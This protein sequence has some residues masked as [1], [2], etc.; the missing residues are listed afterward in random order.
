VR[1]IARD[2]AGWTGRPLDILLGTSPGDVFRYPSVVTSSPRQG[3]KLLELL[4][5]LE[6]LELDL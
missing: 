2:A 6:P 1:N 5:L 4:E 3:D